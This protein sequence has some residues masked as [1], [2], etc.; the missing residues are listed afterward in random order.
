VDSLV[1]VGGKPLAGAVR[2]GGAKNAALPCMAAALLS[3]AAVTIEN[4]PRLADIRTII[5]LLRHLGV[6]VD[7]GGLGEGRVT[8]QAR[9]G[10]ELTAP[11]DLVRTMRASVLVLGP[12]VARFGRARVSLPGGCAIGPRPINLHLAGLE[13]LGAQIT[14]SDGYVEAKAPRL[15]GNRIV[16]DL[17]TV[18]GTENLMMAAAL[19]E[20][21]TV[22][23]NAAC[24]PEV[25]DLAGLLNAM[26]GRVHG[27]G[28]MTVTVEGVGA[29]RGATHRLVPDRIETGTFAVAAAITGGDVRIEGCEPAHLEAVPAKLREGGAR[30]E[31]G[32]GTVRVATSGRL[33]GVD[34]QTRTYP[35][36]ATD[37]Q[38][39]MMALMALAE[40]QSAITETI[41]ENRFM[42][43]NELLRM[44]ADIRVRGNTAVVRGVPSLSGAP[45]MATDLR[46]SASLVLAGLAAEGTTRVSRIYHLDRGYEALE[47]K[48]RGLGAEVRREAA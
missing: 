44:G 41:F 13:K 47:V 23:E 42:H 40:G 2:V 28:T 12:L 29:L 39:Q 31:A 25:V 36:F 27:A 11:Y 17:Q 7:A 18:T 16:F 20:G 24:E 14:L 38:A 9:R 30:S 5:R 3:E 6:A 32:E 37:M 33:R 10:A 1:I 26:G 48:L 46:A 15:R 4:V 21:T 19:A 34:V 22:L 43:V 45:V 35:G 8:L